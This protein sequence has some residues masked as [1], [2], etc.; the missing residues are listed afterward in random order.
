MQIWFV[1]P[2]TKGMFTLGAQRTK[3]WGGSHGSG[4]VLGHLLAIFQVSFFVSRTVS[5]NQFYAQKLS[6]VEDSHTE[7]ITDPQLPWSARSNV[8]G[9]LLSRW[10]TLRLIICT[11]Q[12]NVPFSAISAGCMAIYCSL[13]THDWSC[14]VRQFIQSASSLGST[15]SKCASIC[16]KSFSQGPDDF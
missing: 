4:V 2:V 10:G 7:S 13:A 6:P 1:Q 14:S 16:V 9:Y 12:I 3:V 15:L 11:A 8:I 5:G